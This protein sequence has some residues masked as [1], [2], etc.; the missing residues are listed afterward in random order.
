VCTDD[1]G[2]VFGLQP[3]SHEVTGDACDL[4]LPYTERFEFTVLSTNFAAIILPIEWTLNAAKTP[5]DCF[6]KTISEKL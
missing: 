3:W 6:R 5:F 2:V 4:L 1:G